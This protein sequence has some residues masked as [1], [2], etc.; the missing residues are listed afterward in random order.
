LDSHDVVVVG[1]GVGGLTASW[2]L[3]DRDVV[4]LEA[5][6]R[7]GGRIKSWRHGDYWVSVGAHMFPG[8]TTMLGRLVGELGLHVRPI[9]ASLLN[10]SY[11]EQVIPESRPELWPLRLPLTAAGR[12]GL[13]RPGLK[14]KA[15]GRTYGKLREP[16]P[17]DIDADVRRRLLGFMDDRS[18][19]EFIGRLQPEV[20]EVMRVAANRLTCEMDECAAGCLVGL[21]EGAWSIGGDNHD[22]CLDGGPSLL[23]ETMAHRLGDR[24]KLG[25]RVDSIEWKEGRGVHVRFSDANGQKEISAR[26]AIVTPP[27]PIARAMIADLP[28]DTA[29]ALDGITYGPHVVGGVVTKETGPMPWDGMYSLLVVGRSFNMLFNHSVTHRDPAVP[30]APGGTLMVYAGAGVARP[31]LALTDDEIATRFSDDIVAIFPEAR[32]VIDSVTIQRWP[33]SIAFAAPG[34]SRLQPTLERGVGGVLFFAGDYVGE[35]T[36]MESAVITA[37]EAAVAARCVLEGG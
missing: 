5:E 21:F 29:R 25:A 31:L 33:Y 35:W 12:A 22:G 2:R 13:I 36:H 34:R 17:G 24:V 7:V 32:G 6:E 37:S 23:P 26:T 8:P 1:G 10:I 14:L 15:A 4:L 3:R 27:A 9:R 18:F 20:E 30:R 16:R 19:A 28:P 11:H